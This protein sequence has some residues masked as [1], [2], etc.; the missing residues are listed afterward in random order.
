MIGGQEF[1]VCTPPLCTCFLFLEQQKPPTGSGQ[2]TIIYSLPVAVSDP[3]F[4]VEPEKVILFS[5]IYLLSHISF[6][7][8][9]LL[10]RID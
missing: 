1:N 6:Q 8:D 2:K 10:G 9:R 7:P 4:S 5:S 3:T